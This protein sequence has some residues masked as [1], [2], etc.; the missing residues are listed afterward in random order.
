MST[1]QGALLLTYNSALRNNKQTNSFWLGVAIQCAKE[2]DA[3]RYHS[4]P[5]LTAERRNALK[6]LWWCCIL[7]D[8]ILPLG[9]R[10]PLQISAADFDFE[11]AP[12]TK[13]DFENEIGRSKVYSSCTKNSLVDIFLALCSLAVSLTEVIMTVY[14]TN[15]SIDSVLLDEHKVGQTFDRIESSKLALNLWF[16][17]ATTEFLTPAAIGNLHESTTLYTNL[18]YMY[19]Q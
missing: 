19:Y 15:E 6:R 4:K 9:V 18:M 2:A 7:R 13:D 14:P 16:D 17:K 11:V 5:G 8:R 10:R 3:H 1:A 12:L